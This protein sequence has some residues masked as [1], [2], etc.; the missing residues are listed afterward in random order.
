MKK[1]IFSLGLLLLASFSHANVQETWGQ[2][3]LEVKVVD[4]TVHDDPIKRNIAL[5]PSLSLEG[6]ILLFNTPCEGYTLRFLNEN[7]VVEYS[8]VI[9]ANTTSLELPPYLSGE[10]EIQLIRGQFCFFG[11]VEL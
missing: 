3:S 7:G 4:P 2:L 1:I 9:P 8:I 5:I 10:Y 11:Y 6:H